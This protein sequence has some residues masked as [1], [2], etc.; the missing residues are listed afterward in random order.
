[1]AGT[2]RT[3]ARSVVAARLAPPPRGPRACY[4]VSCTVVAPSESRR[5]MN[6]SAVAAIG[7]RRGAGAGEQPG[8]E[9]HGTPGLLVGNAVVLSPAFGVVA[10]VVPIVLARDWLPLEGAYAAQFVEVDAVKRA[11]E[12]L[13]TPLAFEL[14]YLSGGQVGVAAADRVVEPHRL[15]LTHDQPVAM[16]S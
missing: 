16:Y 10:T 14:L 15:P 13:A 7:V 8:I 2:R 9:L 12:D 11:P 4:A 6:G 5:T 3:L 1:M